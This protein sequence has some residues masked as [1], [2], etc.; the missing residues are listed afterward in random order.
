MR[1]RLGTGRKTFEPR[2]VY[3]KN[4]EPA[5][6]VVVVKRNPAAGSFQKVYV[7]VL[8]AENCLRVEPGLAPNVDEANAQAVARGLDLRRSILQQARVCPQPVRTRQLQDALE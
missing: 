2:T 1:S 6:V 5:I 8:T 3:E 7:L 4:I